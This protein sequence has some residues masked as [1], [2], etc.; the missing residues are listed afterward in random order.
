MEKRWEV[1][2]EVEVVV[3][4]ALFFILGIPTAAQ[5]MIPH[6][7]SISIGARLAARAVTESV[8]EGK[9]GVKI[10]HT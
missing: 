10:I 7:M 6:I 2:Y 3:V 4:A 8:A 1:E 5:M 9:I